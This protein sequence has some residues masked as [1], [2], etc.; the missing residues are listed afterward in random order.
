MLPLWGNE[1]VASERVPSMNEKDLRSISSDALSKTAKLLEDGNVV[2]ASVTLLT[3]VTL[4]LV[5]IAASMIRT[6]GGE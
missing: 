5:E 6:R 1:R 3:V 4:A 2:G